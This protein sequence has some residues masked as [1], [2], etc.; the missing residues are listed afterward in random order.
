VH[1]VGTM[2]KHN[3]SNVRITVRREKMSRCNNLHNEREVSMPREGLTPKYKVTCQLEVTSR[4]YGTGV[5][6]RIQIGAA[7]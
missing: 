2:Q 4:L 5:E 3:R 1:V 7:L 6:T